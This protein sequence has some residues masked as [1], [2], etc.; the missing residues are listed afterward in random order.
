MKGIHNFQGFQMELKK[1]EIIAD[2]IVK[3]LSEYCLKIEIAGSIRRRK[4]HVR[5]IEIVC[6]PRRT[7]MRVGLF[8]EERRVPGFAAYLNQFERIKGNPETG[9]YIQLKH[10]AGINID[11]FVASP[12]NWGNILAIRTGPASFSKF[13]M[14]K[15]KERGLQFEG[16]RVYMQS[17]QIAV[18]DEPYLFKLL[19]EE[20]IAPEFR[21]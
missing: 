1:A 11:V 2:K 6:I 5:D 7:I 15:G 18:P 17:K 19:D 10:P 13:L 21:I 14:I 12:E 16:G 4:E 8:G 20:Y 3:D 9:K